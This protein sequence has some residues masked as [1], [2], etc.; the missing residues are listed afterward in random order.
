MVCKNNVLTIN[1][2][3]YI[4]ATFTQTHLVTLVRREKASQLD[5]KQEENCLA[6]PR[7]Q[8]EFWVIA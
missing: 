4:L 5:S 8:I 6:N 1:R 2:L 7:E 3:G